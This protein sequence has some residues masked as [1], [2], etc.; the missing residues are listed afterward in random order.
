MTANWFEAKV[1]YVKVGEDGKEKKMS[2]L[3]L[4][5]AMSYTEAES[6]ITENLREMIQGDFYIVGLK[7]SNI[8][9]LVV[10]GADIDS[11]LANLHKSLSTYVVPFE[12]SSLADTNIMD[13]FPYFSDDA[14][15]KIPS[16]LKPLDSIE[17][18]L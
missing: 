9:E 13:V 1:K 18:D 17:A 2:E 12:I 7:K 11:A 5:D 16:N 15:Q 4:L 10:A 8:T 3:Y 14:D 6:R